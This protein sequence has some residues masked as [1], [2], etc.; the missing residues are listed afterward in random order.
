[1]G[2]GEKGV[3]SDFG[4]SHFCGTVARKAGPEWVEWG[5]Q[6]YGTSQRSSAVKGTR[7]VGW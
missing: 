7:G 1:M 5:K 4:K 3:I 2:F 6:G